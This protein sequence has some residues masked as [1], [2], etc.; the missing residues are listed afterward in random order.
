[1]AAFVFDVRDGKKAPKQQQR[2]EHGFSGFHRSRCHPV[3]NV[4]LSLNM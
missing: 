4:A 3:E 1:M 2:P